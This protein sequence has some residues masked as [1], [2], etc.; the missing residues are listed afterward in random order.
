MNLL[1]YTKSE[2]Q[3][4][5]TQKG[6]PFRY[7]Y[8]STFGDYPETRT[9]VNRGITTDL[10][11]TFFTDSR[12]PKVEQI[13]KNPKVSALFYD[14]NKQLQVRLYGKASLITQRDPGYDAYQKQVKSNADWTKDYAS[15]N[16]PGVPKKDEGTIIY[17]NTMHL[18]VVKIKPIALD[19]V[20]L[21]SKQ[22]R[23]SKCKLVEGIWVETAVVA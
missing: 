19:I 11:I 10:E 23:R 15:L 3:L 16:V 14:P 21:G 22:H 20:L 7:F 1:P 18:T 6:H 17:G 2:F 12:T 9:V 8:L 4:S 13:K 5:N